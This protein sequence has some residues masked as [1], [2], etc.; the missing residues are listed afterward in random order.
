VDHARSDETHI[1]WR[2]IVQ[3]TLGRAGPAREYISR[4]RGGDPHGRLLPGEPNKS[5]IDLTP[6]GIE[7]DGKMAGLPPKKRESLMGQNL[8]GRNCQVGNLEGMG[9]TPA[10]E[11]S[12][13][14]G[15]IGPGPPGGSDKGQ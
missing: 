14:N 10:K 3:H 11:M 1:P 12:H 7:K 2:K 4:L 9:Q 15:G 6:L 8:K 5:G 13:P